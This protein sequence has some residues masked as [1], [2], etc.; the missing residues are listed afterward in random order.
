[1]ATD[2]DVVETAISQSGQ[3]AGHQPIKTCGTGENLCGFFFFFLFIKS[4][5]E[6]EGEDR[7]AVKPTYNKKQFINPEM[8][9]WEHPFN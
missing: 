6:S 8:F 3:T 7:R 4:I 9:V 2:Q 1:M 5:A